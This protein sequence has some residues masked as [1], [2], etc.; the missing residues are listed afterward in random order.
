MNKYINCGTLNVRGIKT[1]QERITLAKDATRCELHILSIPET[2]LTEDTLEDI[3]FKDEK[4]KKERH[5]HMCY[6]QPPRLGY[7]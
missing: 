4:A 1:D 2:H 5:I 6:M 7:S 3:T